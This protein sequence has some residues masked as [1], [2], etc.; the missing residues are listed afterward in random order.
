MIAVGGAAV[1][2]VVLGMV[3]CRSGG[4]TDFVSRGRDALEA[5]AGAK[6]ESVPDRQLERFLGL[7]ADF[8]PEAVRDAALA[9]YADDAY[10]N[11]GFVELEG[12]AAI[13]D[14][15]ARSAGHTAAIDVDVE[16]LVQAD[17]E[18][19]IRWVM[20]FD[21]AGSR[22]RTIVAPGISHLR[23]D[24]DGRIVYHHD[25]WDASGALAAFVPLVPSILDAVRKRL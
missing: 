21:T 8:R 16:H 15:L 19:Y 13:A 5:T 14:Y 7:F 12:A 2:L 24:A 1:A 18:V 25:Y 22:S 9:A 4:T 11:D 20:R 6:V 10:F 23:F 3:A 17:G